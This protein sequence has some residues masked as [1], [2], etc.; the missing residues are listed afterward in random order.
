MKTRALLVGIALAAAVSAQAAGEYRTVDVESLRITIDSE[1]AR[2]TGTR[3]QVGR[4]GRSWRSMIAA[5]ACSTSS[6]N[7]QRSKSA[8]LSQI[9]L[10]WKERGSSTLRISDQLEAP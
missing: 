4:I 2:S 6:E 3:M 9:E 10:C 5:R 1:W 7:H 8:R